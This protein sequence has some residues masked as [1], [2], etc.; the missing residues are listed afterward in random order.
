M[1][2]NLELKIKMDS[3]EDIIWRLEQ[4]GAKFETSLEQEDTY[5]KI[6]KGL[7]KLREVNGKFELIKYIRDE[8]GVDRWSDYQLLYLNGENV[9]EYLCDIFEVE[10]VVKKVRK[11]YMFDNTRIHLDTVQQLGTFLELETLVLND[12]AD[13]QKRF[14][15]IVSFL[16]LN[17]E[18]QIRTSYRNLI[19][20]L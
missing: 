17:F 6:K 18:N 8:S 19:L 20:G 16:E 2:R 4:I 5:F 10:T 1:A 7:L 3:H 13:A 9:K 14:D 12:L 11:L 15:T